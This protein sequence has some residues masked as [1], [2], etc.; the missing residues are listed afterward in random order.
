M[1]YISHGLGERI[2]F[3]AAWLSFSY[4]ALF[5]PW[6]LL[7][8]GTYAETGF[9]DA[10]G[11]EVVWW[12]WTLIGTAIVG[13]LALI[14]IKLSVRVDLALA[15]IC[16]AFL[17]LISLIITVKIVGDGSFT[18]EPLSPSNA[19]GNFTG[20]ALAIAFGTVIF[21]G[22]EQSFVL[23]EETE[24]PRQVSQAIIF[25]LGL[26]GTVLFLATFALV[27]SF[28]SDGIGRLNDLF[29]SKGTP[30]FA[31][32][33]ERIGPGWVS[34]LELLIVFSIL[35]NTIASMNAIVR[36]LYGMGRAG[37]LPHALGH[38]LPVRRTPH[39]AIAV[40][41]VFTILLAVIPALVWSTTS[42]FTF[43][44]FGIGFSAAVSF[45][46][47]AVAALRYFQRVRDG[48]SWLSN[49]VVPVV[50]IAILI[51]VVIT[52]FYPNPGPSLKWAPWL[53][54]GWL[55]IGVIYLLVREAK[56]QPLD[57]D[58]FAEVDA[59]LPERALAKEPQ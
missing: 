42:T 53:V 51:P 14:G 49:Y 32:V 37:A 16:D 23:G 35:S 5:V 6:L 48:A 44:G 47:I 21:L 12:V 27:L 28:G 36:I 52:S 50:A 1:P 20:L 38:T 34:G 54:V 7:G 8:L 57:V 19:P 33:R 4:F 40:M 55:A 41:I 31:M 18:L 59:Q 17:V 25:S 11:L 2:G 9:K 3:L 45:I 30:W 13:A 15:L 46:L 26:V 29:A 24:N 22:F 56:D 43:M 10:L 58:Y 39:I